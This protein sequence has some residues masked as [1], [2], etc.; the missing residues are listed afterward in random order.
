MGEANQLALPPARLNVKV[1]GLEIGAT[2]STWSTEPTPD[3]GE[4]A[5]EFTE[6]DTASDDDEGGVKVRIAAA[7]PRT[8]G[9]DSLSCSAFITRGIR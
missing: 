4:P 3:V 8:E 2:T 5:W 7:E 6:A 9:T 1:P